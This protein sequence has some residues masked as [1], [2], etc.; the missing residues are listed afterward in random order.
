MMIS[1]E[2]GAT[3]S[4][5]VY[6]KPCAGL[7]ALHASTCLCEWLLCT[8]PVGSS[9]SRH[10]TGCRLHAFVGKVCQRRGWLKTVSKFV[11]RCSKCAASRLCPATGEGEPSLLCEEGGF[12]CSVS[13]YQGGGH[14]RDVWGREKRWRR[15]RA[16][17]SILLFLRLL[18]HFSSFLPCFI[19]TPLL[20]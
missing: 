19:L 9:C 15:N 16:F 20:A 7:R 2:K 12:S 4:V 10:V 13:K 1:C 18:F 3:V 11:M 17:S 6:R 14:S 5:H 8:G